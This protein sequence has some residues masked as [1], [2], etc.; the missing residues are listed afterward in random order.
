MA[1]V[2]TSVTEDQEGTSLLADEGKEPG[3]SGPPPSTAPEPPRPSTAQ[4]PPSGE[5]AGEPTPAPNT[6]AQAAVGWPATLEELV[7]NSVNI[8]GHRTL[9]GAVMQSFRSVQSGLND[10]VQG[11]LTGFEVSQVMIFPHNAVIVL[12]LSRPHT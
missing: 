7:S 4:I 2:N 6:S 11:L 1:E 9:M 12:S 5:G 8:E 10:A 3:Q